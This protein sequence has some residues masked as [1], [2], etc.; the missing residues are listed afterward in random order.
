MTD[1]DIKPAEPAADQGGEQRDLFPDWELP[2]APLVHLTAQERFLHEGMIDLCQWG[3]LRMYRIR[4]TICF[5]SGEISACTE[6]AKRWAM[7]FN[8]PLRWPLELSDPNENTKKARKKWGYTDFLEIC[9]PLFCVIARLPRS[10]PI[11]YISPCEREQN[12]PLAWEET[13][14]VSH[15]QPM[16]FPVDEAAALA[17]DPCAG[18]NGGA[19]TSR[20]AH[21]RIRPHKREVHDKIM[22]LVRRRGSVTVHEVADGLGTHPHCISGRLTELRISGRLTYQLD[23]EGRRIRR[24]GAYALVSAGP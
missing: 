20:D 24:G 16:L 3:N 6:Y 21:Q 18:R 7:K 13:P 17:A 23:A 9:V 22:A 8:P 10:N 11:H 15:E 2:R 14:M 5:A 4:E 1:R 12:E 19:E